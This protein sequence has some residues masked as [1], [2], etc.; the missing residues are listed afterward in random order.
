MNVLAAVSPIWT[1]PTGV[2]PVLACQSFTITTPSRIRSHVVVVPTVPQSSIECQPV[3][4]CDAGVD[5]GAADVRAELQSAPVAVTTA[6][7]TG[8][9]AAVRR[10]NRSAA[11]DVRFTFTL[12]HGVIVVDGRSRYANA[13]W[14]VTP[15]RADGT[16]GEPIA[17]SIV[18]RV[19]DVHAS[20]FPDV[21]S[22]AKIGGVV[23]PLTVIEAEAPLIRLGLLNESTAS[24]V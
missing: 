19:K 15:A 2:V 5:R 6:L 23:P 8:P 1:R 12:K 9:F 14:F 22:S 18:I 11:P 17:L 24:T 13:D 10:R 20:M 3:P 7:M 4:S 21:K 16:A